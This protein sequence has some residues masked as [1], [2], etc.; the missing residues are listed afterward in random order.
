MIR[1]K[2]CEAFHKVCKKIKPEVLETDPSI[3]LKPVV[4]N[5]KRIKQTELQTQ[6]EGSS[7]AV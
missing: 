2:E 7:D 6:R 1:H 4:R 5:E 3:T